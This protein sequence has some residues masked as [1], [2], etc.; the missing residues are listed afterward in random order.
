MKMEKLAAA[1]SAA[2]IS[3]LSQSAVAADAKCEL[4]RPVV[5][6]GLDWDSNA[7]HNAIAQFIVEEGYGCNTD[8]IPGSTIPLMNGMIRGDIDV[9]MEMWRDNVRD[10][11]DPAVEKELVF[12]LG[13][14]F[15]DATQEWYVPKYLVEGDGAPA[16]DLRS[17]SDLAKYK[18]LFADPEEPS[19]GRF[20]NCVIGWGCE[21]VN[22]KKYYAYGLDADFT[23]FRPGSGGAFAAAIE[24]AVLKK[25]PIFF[26][27]W[28]PTWLLGKIGDQLVRLEEPTYNAEIWQRM[29]DTENPEDVE[30]ATAYPVV[31]VTVSVNGPFHDEAPKLVEFLTN[32]E[33][34]AKMV[35]ELL[36]WMQDNNGTPESAAKEFLSSREEVWTTWVPEDVAARVRDALSAS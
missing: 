32:Y 2:A 1:A 24:G 18:E 33:T 16:P 17:V 34:T 25:Q 35:S 36:A 10:V 20:Y 26:Y 28:G 6:A 7:V 13:P 22:T 23:N 27:Y 19:K 21:K 4:D 31:E 14:N 12:D 29:Q 11:Y 5:F 30:E 8:V 9:T 15:P 3:L